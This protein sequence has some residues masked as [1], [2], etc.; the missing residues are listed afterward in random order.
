MPGSSTGGLPVRSVN[1]VRILSPAGVCNTFGA[2]VFQFWVRTGS[3]SMVDSAERSAIVVASTTPTPVPWIRLPMS[4]PSVLPGPK[5]TI[6]SLDGS[7]DSSIA[8]TRAAQST[9]LSSTSAA[10]SRVRVSL[11]PQACAQATA[12]ST[13][14]AISGEWNGSVTSRYSRTGPNTAPPRTFSSRSVCWRLCSL[15]ASTSKAAR[16]SG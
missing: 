1:L 16:S 2:N 15:P 13:A 9:W 8:L 14:S 3:S 5:S 12:C 4:L 7:Q 11:K 6:H 10:S